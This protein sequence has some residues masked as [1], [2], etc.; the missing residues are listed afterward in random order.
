MGTPLLSIIIKIRYASPHTFFVSIVCFWVPFARPSIHPLKMKSLRRAI[1][2][3]KKAESEGRG[4][5]WCQKVKDG[6]IISE[7]GTARL[8]AMMQQRTLKWKLC[9]KRA[10]FWK[11]SNLIPPCMSRLSHA[12]CA[13]AL[14][15][16]RVKVL[17]W[18]ARSKSRCGRDGVELVWKPSFLPLCRCWARVI[19]GR[20]SRATTGVFSSVVEKR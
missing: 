6:E 13:G 15:H 9:A 10:G 5:C 8:V 4:T 17:F 7:G 18:C 20:V 1:E 2:V 19:R 14:L 12:S 11:L 16:S 3:A